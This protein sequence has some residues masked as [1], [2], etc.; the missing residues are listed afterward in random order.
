MDLR[1]CS[2][3]LAFSNKA[4]ERGA[5]RQHVTECVCIRRRSITAKCSLHAKSNPVP[6]RN[7]KKRRPSPPLERHQRLPYS[8]CFSRKDRTPH[9]QWRHSEHQPGARHRKPVIA[10]QRISRD[11]VLLPKPRAKA[12][13]AVGNVV[14]PRRAIRLLGLST[15]GGRVDPS[16]Q[17]TLNHER[18]EEHQKEA[19]RG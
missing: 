17:S 11:L 4:F 16:V 13:Q 10:E 9:E 2:C 3:A 5:P 12:P 18:R 15:S 7:R 19:D 1:R 14:T 8:Q 6:I